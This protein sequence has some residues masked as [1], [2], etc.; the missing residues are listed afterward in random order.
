MGIWAEERMTSRI[1]VLIHW[2]FPRVYE[3]TATSYQPGKA[4]YHKIGP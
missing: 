3:E 1:L 2:H 4:I